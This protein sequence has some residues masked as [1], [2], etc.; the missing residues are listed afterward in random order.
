MSSEIDCTRGD[1]RMKLEVGRECMKVEKS[2]CR[3]ERV[4]DW[5]WSEAVKCIHALVSIFVNMGID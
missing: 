5:K 1:L 3:I 4:D 2:E